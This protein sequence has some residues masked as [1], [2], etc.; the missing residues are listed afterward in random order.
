VADTQVREQLP[1]RPRAGLDDL[2]AYLA[3]H[4]RRALDGLGPGLRTMVRPLGLFIASRVVVAAAIGVVIMLHI[5]LSTHHFHGSSF[6][7]NP[8]KG[9]LFEALG[10]YDGS[11]YMWIAAHGYTTQLHPDSFYTPSV[12]FLPLLPVV[13]RATMFLTG[14][15]VLY[16][17][18][19]TTFV[20]G[21]VASICVWVFVR[22]ITDAR[23][24]DRATALWCFFPGAMTLS[25]VYSEG[26]LVILAVVCLFALMRGRWLIAGLAAA[27]A[28]ATSPEG[29]ALTACCAWAAG[30][31]ILRPPARPTLRGRWV[32]LVAPLL[33][34]TGWITYHVYLWRRT[35]DLTFWYRVENEFWH[36]GF[37]PWTATVEKARLAFDHPGMPDYLVPTLGLF[38]LVAAAILLWRWKPPAVVTIYAAVAMAFV[39]SSGPL[40]ARPRFFIA[41]FPFVV[42]LARP[43]RGPA[44]N[45]M[46]GVAAGALG[47]LTLIIAS[48]VTAALA[49]TP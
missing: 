19:L 2:R 43:T 38:V 39:L 33:A 42:A 27:A 6:P 1:A 16:A 12:A 45:A 20:T 24:A 44:F 26:L 8:P 17:G 11:W 49:F 10:M 48:G 14:L 34:P 13:I 30:A 25:L 5:G 23:T 28:S 47:L 32:A 7:L 22:H 15:N 41:A 35:G 9:S 3:R 31:A 46:L 21:A 37:Q 36:G 40:G 18:V 4:G 29:L